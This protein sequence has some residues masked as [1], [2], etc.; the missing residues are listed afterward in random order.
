MRQ[1]PNKRMQLTALYSKGNVGLCGDLE[2]AAADARS[3]RQSPQLMRGPLDGR[4]S[5]EAR[6]NVLIT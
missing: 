3:V 5:F 2:V 4:I 1:R 6:W